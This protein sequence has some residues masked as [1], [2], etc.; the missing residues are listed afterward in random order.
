MSDLNEYLAQKREALLIRNARDPATLK[1]ET[2]TARSTAEGRSGIRH[3][4]IRDHHIISDSPP[5]FAGYNL[6]PASPEI[7]IGS[8]SSCLTH[9]FLIHAAERKI[10]LTR[11][12]VEVQADVD[13]RGGKEG[14]ENTPFYPFN[15]RYTVEIDSTADEAEITA[16][17]QAVEAWCPVLNL[18]KNPQPIEGAIRYR[19]VDA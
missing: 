10:P 8:L 3:I 7:F 5:D 14:Y 19:Q 13:V 6:G 1:K 18:I 17:H 11:L 15:L 2:I 4:R 16:L 9:I 12:E